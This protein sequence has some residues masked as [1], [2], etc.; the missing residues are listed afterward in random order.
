MSCRF[1]T[2]D[3][4][5]I[6]YNNYELLA[7]RAYNELRAKKLISKDLEI[8]TQFE[9]ATEFLFQ[10]KLKVVCDRGH[11]DSRADGRLPLENEQAILW[12]CKSAEGAVNLQDYLE[13]Q[14]DGY[15]RKE[16]ESGKQPLAFLVIGPSFTSQSIKLAH[17]YKARTNWDIALVTAEGLKH[18]AERWVATQPHKPFPVRL[19]NR[20][21]VID[22]ERAEFLLSLA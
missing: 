17:Q 3:E 4:R 13:D 20:T 9:N 16:R 7:S 19:L 8:Q 21:E 6:W 10:T 11:K 22:K 2:K 14:F 15:L 12:D 5:E 18:L 1:A